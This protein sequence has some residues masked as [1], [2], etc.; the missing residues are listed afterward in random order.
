MNNNN[1]KKE[2]TLTQTGKNKTTQSSSNNNNTKKK[3]QWDRQSGVK[4]NF[5]VKSNNQRRRVRHINPTHTL[6]T[7][8]FS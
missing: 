8:N 3:Y 2:T 1:K 5:R 7:G 4:N 6:F